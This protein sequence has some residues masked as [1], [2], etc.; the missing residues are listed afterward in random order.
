MRIII[1]MI[2]IITLNSDS[3]GQVYSLIDKYSLK[4]K[5]YYELQDSTI[6]RDTINFN[7][8]NNSQKN[9][10]SIDVWGCFYNYR[11]DIE[12]D[13]ADTVGL[14]TA[15]L[16]EVKPVKP[17][18]EEKQLFTPNKI[19]YK[20]EWRLKT[21]QSNMSSQFSS[22]LLQIITKVDFDGLPDRK[23]LK[24]DV[25]LIQFDGTGFL[26][27]GEINNKKISYSINSLYLNKHNKLLGLMPIEKLIFDYI[28]DN[29]LEVD[30]N[31]GC[32]YTGGSS[33]WRCLK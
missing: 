23:T 19:K 7:P 8:F 22:E 13:D 24:N 18:K 5:G 25:K 26:F 30:M 14:F 27:D 6:Y 17:S 20:N 29:D 2:L 15:Y 33:S 31:K 9:H 1:S 4:V 32:C 3:F 16:Y 10:V 11:F 12:F 21:K 28:K